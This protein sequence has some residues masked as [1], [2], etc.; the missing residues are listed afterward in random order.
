MMKRLDN[1]QWGS[2]YNSDQA[3]TMVNQI[4]NNKLSAQTTEMMKVVSENGYKSVCEIGCGS[5]QTVLCLAKMGVHVVALDYQEE[6]LELI[7][8]A[9]TIM[10][11]KVVQNIETILADARTKLPFEE[12]QF[13]L[14]YHAGLMEHFS[15]IERIEM[16]SQWKD[17]CHNMISMVP[18]GASVAYRYGKNKMINEN[19]WPYGQENIIYTQILEFIKAGLDVDTEYT[20][21]L[22]N[23]LNFLDDKNYLKK[24]M[25]KLWAENIMEDDCHQGYLLLTSGRRRD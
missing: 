5:G 11:D 12:K 16:L 24:A 17:Y 7:K 22:P 21:G 25:K 1:K 4:N 9:A 14:I 8:R 2:L 13:D 3:Q 15:E 6:S 18:N 20:I 19:R 23:S 10:G